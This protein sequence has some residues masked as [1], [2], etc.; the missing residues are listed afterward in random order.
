MNPSSGRFWSMDTYEGRNQD[1]A[2]L[3][4]Y[5]YC[6]NNPANLS[7]PSGR[8]F[9]LASLQAAAASALT[10]VSITT[11]QAAQFLSSVGEKLSEAFEEGGNPGAVFNELGAQAEFFAEETFEAVPDIDVI[12]EEVSVNGGRIIDFVVRSGDRL[13]AIEVKYSFGL[14]SAEAL[15]R[16]VAQVSGALQGGTYQRVVLWALQP[17]TGEQLFRLNQALESAGVGGQVSIVY[18]VNGLAAWS[19]LF[20]Q[21]FY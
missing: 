18:G 5:L 2:S 19:A 8:D 1:P 11:L 4:K 9:S 15:N 6:G 20:T 12:E 13:A 16:A 17:P 10:L 14:R 7:D 21:G 3:H